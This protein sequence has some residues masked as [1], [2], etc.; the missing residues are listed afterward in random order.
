MSYRRFGGD[1]R[2][3][4]DMAGSKITSR[5]KVLSDVTLRF[6]AFPDVAEDCSTFETSWKY[7]VTQSHIPEKLNH[8]HPP[9]QN[10]KHRK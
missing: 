3:T 5:L 6:G 2:W 8:L 1:V 9:C 4:L 10:L 7:P